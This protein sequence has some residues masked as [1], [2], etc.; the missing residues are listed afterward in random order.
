LVTTGFPHLGAVKSRAAA[1]AARA[2][3]FI[4]RLVDPRG[5]G[6][7]R[8]APPETLGALI[9][10]MAEQRELAS[11]G[12][13]GHP[14]PRG[15]DQVL[16][17][18]QTRSLVAVIDGDSVR[19]VNSADG[20]EAGRLQSKGRDP[21]AHPFGLIVDTKRRRAITTRSYMELDFWDID[22]MEHLKSLQVQQ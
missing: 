14:P 2:D 3:G 5:I 6:L 18:T 1:R 22:T 20:T 10:A 13:S 7:D 12:Q 8:P 19:L 4:A 11:W 9:E 21:G 15:T 16:A 17:V